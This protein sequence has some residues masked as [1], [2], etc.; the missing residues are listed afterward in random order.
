MD[1]TLY[2]ASDTNAWRVQ[3]ML[4]ELDLPYRHIH[5]DIHA[6][7]AESDPIFKEIVQLNPTA[8]VPLLTRGADVVWDSLAINLYLADVVGRFRPES[9]LIPAVQWSL[10]AAGL[11]DSIRTAQLHHSRLPEAARDSK[12]AAEARSALTRPFDNLDAWLEGSPFLLGGVFTVADIN[13][14]CVL[15]H[16][17][18]SGV[19]AKRWPALQNWMGKCGSRPA[20]A[21]L[22]E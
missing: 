18:D 20:L 14:V 22:F 3:W 5:F 4:N 2:G 15:A 13:V 11:E 10:W 16:M 7:G 21:R 17:V 8:T 6:E 9:G 19:E 12:I 1:I